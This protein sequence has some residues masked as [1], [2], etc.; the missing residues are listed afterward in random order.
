MNPQAILYFFPTA[1]TPAYNDK[2]TTDFER[3]IWALFKIV[4]CNFTPDEDDEEV[5]TRSNSR[6]E[7]HYRES[8]PVG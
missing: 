6:N 4:L 8:D 1:S 2:Y 5:T 7:S 3:L